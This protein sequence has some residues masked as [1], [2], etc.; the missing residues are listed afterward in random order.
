[1]LNIYGADFPLDSNPYPRIG[2]AEARAIEYN[3]GFLKVRTPPA[4]FGL[5]ATYDVS[6]VW[7]MS[8]AVNTAPIPVEARAPESERFTYI[9]DGPPEIIEIEPSQI[10]VDT[11]SGIPALMQPEQQITI[12]G[13][14]FDDRVVVTFTFTD[15]SGDA[16]TT[17]Q[18][19][20]PHFSVSPNRIV[21]ETPHFMSLLDPLLHGDPN[22]MLDL[23]DNDTDPLE[24]PPDGLPDPTSAGNH[25]EVVVT[26][27]NLGDGPLPGPD[28]KLTSNPD[29]IFYVVD[30]DD[31]VDPFNPDLLFNDVYLNYRNYVNVDPGTGSISIE[32]MF[33]PEGAPPIEP[34]PDTLTYPELGAPKPWWRG[35]LE[36]VSDSQPDPEGG[37]AWE[38]DYMNPMR[39][40]GSKHFLNEEPLSERTDKRHDYEVEMRPDGRAD[41]EFVQGVG[42]W[43]DTPGLPD[44][45]ADE[46]IGEGGGGTYPYWYYAEVV[47]N[48]V[49]AMDAVELQVQVRVYGII[50]VDPDGGLAVYLVPQGVDFRDG[51][52]L[53]PAVRDL[54]IRVTLEDY[55][56]GIYFGTNDIDITT[57]LP[58]GNVADGHAAIVMPADISNDPI[59]Q[60]DMFIGDDSTDLLEDDGYIVGQAITG[61]HLLID[62]IP[63]RPVLVDP[64]IGPPVQPSN[65]MTL[66]NAG[67]YAAQGITL[68]DLVLPDI[69]PYG[70][71]DDGVW[72]PETQTSPAGGP[73]DGV[74]D[75]IP[76]SPP[77]PPRHDGTQAFFNVGSISNDYP[78]P[79]P[80]IIRIGP[81]TTA[82]EYL[83]FVDL[84]PVDAGDSPI[85]GTDYYTG[86]DTR[87]VSGFPE[88][89]S[90]PVTVS[91]HTEPPTVVVFNNDSIGEPAIG[92]MEYQYE[93]SSYLVSYNPLTLPQPLFGNPGFNRDWPIYVDNYENDVIVSE[94]EFNDGGSAG[95]AYGKVSSGAPIHLNMRFVGVDLAGNV[96]GMGYKDGDALNSLHVWWMTEAETVILPDLDGEELSVLPFYWRINRATSEDPEAQDAA[97][98]PRFIWGLWMSP[99]FDDPM[100]PYI[101]CPVAPF[102]LHPAVPVWS[103][104]TQLADVA[105]GLAENLRQS[106]YGGMWFLLVVIGVD[107]AGNYEIWPSDD[108]ELVGEN[109]TQIKDRRRK[110]WVRFYLTGGE[111]D[112]TLTHELWHNGTDFT[113]L[114]DGTPPIADENFGPADIIALH[115]SSPDP[116]VEGLFRIGVE[117]PPGLEGENIAV[118]W[119]LQRDGGEIY[120]AA[121]P[122]ELVIAGY[123]SSGEIRT[124]QLPLEVPATLGDPQ[125]DPYLGFDYIPEG[126]NSVSY[127]L[128][129]QAFWDVNNDGVWQDGER[130]D[131]TPATVRFRV[132]RDTTHSVEG[133][134]RRERQRGKQQIILREG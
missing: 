16:P 78:R 105:P 120:A 28:A 38:R 71:A 99:A 98:K 31:L 125:L 97:V 118:L 46:I 101:P 25:Y 94:W 134:Y 64:T 73:F 110:N 29:S 75:A 129:A 116:R 106:G 67:S 72:R 21:I 69:H 133:Y 131:N 62:T 47:P 57:K 41:T 40:K 124:L 76:S 43:S 79:E 27:T 26:V 115:D 109:I 34:T 55:G 60:F 91:D 48:P 70:P 108:L 50:P 32:P 61:R 104:D 126:Q 45:G 18:V 11:S 63:P 5:P 80:L 96:T 102:P 24:G 2:P 20:I 107:E 113:I 59:D 9:T 84:P 68:P 54:C 17:A 77:D 114:G 83:A 52:L 36:V 7:R 87:E 44:I 90:G 8:D 88:T 42:P 37:D 128:S 95:I 53:N 130:I 6:A 122:D 12:T 30:N 19:T 51:A 121:P 112:T 15:E 1:M 86:L 119:S 13:Y 22:S 33:L 93:V 123:S 56:E 49:P 85:L 132:V 89:L 117:L 82:G 81:G 4:P 10:Y 92:E 23:Y 65:I 66:D 127:V 103:T 39:D 58:S 3:S 35:K 74:L 14:N 111:I 100:Y